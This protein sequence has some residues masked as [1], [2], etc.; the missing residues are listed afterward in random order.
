M[1][2]FSDVE[3]E[4]PAD[5]WVQCDKCD[6]W[7]RVAEEPPED[8]SWECSMM[9]PHVSCSSKE[10]LWRDDF[11]GGTVPHGSKSSKHAQAPKAGKRKL[12]AHGDTNGASDCR[13]VKVAKQPKVEGAQVGN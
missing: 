8:I 6:Q 11:D 2:R 5:V 12:Q 10:N 3:A 7:R 4:V 1:Q 13:K 9:G